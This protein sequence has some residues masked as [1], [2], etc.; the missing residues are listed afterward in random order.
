MLRAA[1][2]RRRPTAQPRRTPLRR[3]R[4]LDAT[5]HRRDAARSD[6]SVRRARPLPSPLAARRL[7]HAA[8]SPLRVRPRRGPARPQPVAACNTN[9]GST[10]CTRS[11]SS[12]C[13]R[14][15]AC[16]I[17]GSRASSVHARACAAGE[18]RACLQ[19]DD[20]RV[21]AERHRIERPL[22]QRRLG[23]REVELA[24]H[25]RREQRAACRRSRA[26]SP[27]RRRRAA[28]TGRAAR[29]GRGSH[30]RAAPQRRLPSSAARSACA[31][32][33][34]AISGVGVASRISPAGVSASGRVPRERSISR[35]PDQPLEGGDLV[36]DRRLHVAEARRGAPE[37]PFARDRVER[38]E[39]AHL[40]AGPPLACHTGVTTVRCA[41][42]AAKAEA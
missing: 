39:V 17:S 31:A 9:R 16:A 38:D 10:P 42:A 33:T 36:A 22:G 26:A 21:C 4:R 28:A 2:H 35:L 37:R 12:T 15:G 5:P 30:R 7:R 11:C 29:A 3:A 8:R 27:E 25:E 14:V 20:E 13:V 23:E 18:R 1:A 24:P 19:D 32:R 40:D 41:T 6:H 34:R